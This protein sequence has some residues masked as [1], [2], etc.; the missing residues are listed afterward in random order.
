L[1]LRFLHSDPVA[2]RVSKTNFLLALVFELKKY[3]LD[4]SCMYDMM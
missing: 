1:I 2:C 4:I 3:M